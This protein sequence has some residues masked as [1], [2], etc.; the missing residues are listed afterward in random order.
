M[1]PPAAP[2]QRR[3]AETPQLTPVEQLCPSSGAA[4]GSTAGRSRSRKRSSS[5][6][7]RKVCAA[8][9]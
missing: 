1:A 3:R 8:E 5:A 2:R 9:I 7:A 4:S 6:T